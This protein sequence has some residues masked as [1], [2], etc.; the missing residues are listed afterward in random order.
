MV[1]SVMTSAV[2]PHALIR[3]SNERVTSEVRGLNGK[4]VS[5]AGEANGGEGN[6]IYQYSWN[7]L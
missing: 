4:G 5:D 7:H 2:N 6:H 3:F 1:S